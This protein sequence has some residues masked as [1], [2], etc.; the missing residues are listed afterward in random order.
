[1]RSRLLTFYWHVCIAGSDTMT[2]Q[3]NSKAKDQLLANWVFCQKLNAANPASDASSTKASTCLNQSTESANA[4]KSLTRWP[5]KIAICLLSRWAYL[6]F[7]TVSKR[8]RRQS[9]KRLSQTLTGIKWKGVN[10]K[11]IKSL[12]DFRWWANCSFLPSIVS[13]AKLLRVVSMTAKVPS[14][15]KPKYGQFSAKKYPNYLL[16][17]WT[18]KTIHQV[19]ASYN[20]SCLCQAS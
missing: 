8:L 1:M 15:V 20:C 11:L 4:A 17:T 5:N 2:T 19:R 10:P 6:N 14:I 16:L 9:D 12:V 3:P 13:L 18:G 7:C